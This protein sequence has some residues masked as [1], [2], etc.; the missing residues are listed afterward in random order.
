MSAGEEQ[1]SA[2][3]GEPPTDVFPDGNSSTGGTEPQADLVRLPEKPIRVPAVKSTP[4]ADPG[5]N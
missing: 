5:M 1:P 4:P 3:S 2:S